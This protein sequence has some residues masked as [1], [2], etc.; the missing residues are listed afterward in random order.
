MAR[1]QYNTRK[2]IA[3]G[4]LDVALLLSN[5]SRIKKLLVKD[6]IEMPTCVAGITFLSV[7]IILQIVVG[8]MLILL[9]I[10][11][12]HGSKSTHTNGEVPDQKSHGHEGDD[13]FID[14]L[15]DKT[16]KGAL[17]RPKKLFRQLTIEEQANELR[18]DKST[19]KLNT[20]VLILVFIIVVLNIVIDGMNLSEAPSLQHQWGIII[21]TSMRKHV[22]GHHQYNSQL[23]IIDFIACEC[24]RRILRIA[25]VYVN[26][27][28]SGNFWCVNMYNVHT[29]S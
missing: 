15:N 1:I 8:I 23:W 26:W 14:L 25:M 17:K 6:C 29:G 2:S 13:S 21:T 18:N 24:Q 20:A 27:M 19:M 7:S 9:G 28:H 12:Q 3:K 4:M 11:E 16:D 10:R 22:W 5:V